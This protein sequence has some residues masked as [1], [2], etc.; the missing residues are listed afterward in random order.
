MA[1]LDN[2]RKF[3]STAILVASATLL[4]NIL[5]FSDI[6][7]Y[8]IGRAVPAVMLML[9]GYSAYSG[10]VNRKADVV[11]T[12]LTF[13]G[14]GL[15]ISGVILLIHYGLGTWEYY[16]VAP[17]GLILTALGLSVRDGKEVSRLW[18]NTF[19]ILL[20]L[21][22]LFAVHEMIMTLF[23]YHMDA[24]STIGR[25]GREL[26]LIVNALLLYFT[27]SN[28]VQRKFELPFRRT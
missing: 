11:F 7:L 17:A 4:M 13:Y 23:N 5:V 22:A 14:T 12:Y 27:L 26:F 2:I 9:I 3:G 8:M 24:I 15:F 25:V 20:I 18:W 19:V 1:Y 10:R 28:D 16:V 6:P 21:L